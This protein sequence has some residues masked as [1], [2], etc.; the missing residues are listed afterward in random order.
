[1]TNE[2]MIKALQKIKNYCSASLLDELDNAIEVL[3]KLEKDGITDPLHTD[4]TQLK[5]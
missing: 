3:K 5:K 4:F 1:M 2:Q